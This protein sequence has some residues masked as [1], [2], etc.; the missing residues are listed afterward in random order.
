MKE[1]NRRRG[2]R[3]PSRTR[4]PGQL[5]G[6]AFDLALLLLLLR[7]GELPHQHLSLLDF[8]LY[9]PEEWEPSVA[10]SQSFANKLNREGVVLY[11]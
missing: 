3:A 2:Q 8:L 6:R 4:V 11:G 1:N 9:T 10:D 7:E 5:Q